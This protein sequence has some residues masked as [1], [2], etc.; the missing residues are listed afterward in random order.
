[1]C[2]IAHNSAI[3]LE[4]S[5]YERI[6]NMSNWKEM[7]ECEMKVRGETMADL[8]ANTLTDTDMVM[9]FYSGFGG[10]NGA[11][12]T[13]WTAKTVYF[14]ACYDGAEWVGSVSRH[15]DGIPTEH[16]GG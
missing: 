16:Q 11:P 13:A 4:L 2:Y 7:L 6:D 15:P 3:M 1:M 14:P 12:F 9:D 5:F 10:I 8:E